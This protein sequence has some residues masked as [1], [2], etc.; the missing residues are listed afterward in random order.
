MK[1]SLILVTSAVAL[2]GSGAGVGIAAAASHPTTARAAQAATL[3]TRMTSY[4][5]ILV[6]AKGSTVYLWVKDKKGS[7]K[8]ACTKACQAVWPLL[9]VSGK[10]TAGPGVNKKLLGTFKVEGK[11]EVTYNG[12]PLY[13]FK[14]DA[15]P[16]QIKGEGNKTFGGAWW[17]VS[18]SGNAITHRPESPVIY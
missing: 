1:S 16:G 13:T 3:S 7:K 14:T 2:V 9:T 10:A 17:L 4:G 5:K 15:R 8:T 12:W 11:T 6:N 18:P